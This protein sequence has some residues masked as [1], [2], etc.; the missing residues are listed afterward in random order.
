MLS[1]ALSDARELAVLWEAVLGRLQIEVNA[2]AF[3][4]Y[5]ADT[6]A[7]RVEAGALVVETP[8]PFALEG[9]N[10]LFRAVA[11]RE[12]TAVA[13]CELGVSF[14]PHRIHDIPALLDGPVQV[15]LPSLVGRLNPAFTFERYVV[16][17]GNR[18]AHGCCR[19]ATAGRPAANPIVLFGRPGVGKTHLLHALAHA[20]RSAGWTIACLSAEEFTNDYQEA[21]RERSARAFQARVRTVRLLIVDDLQYLA[22]K[23]GTQDEF[24]RTIEAVANSG[25]TVAVASEADPDTLALPER[26]ISRLRAGARLPLAPLEEWDRSALTRQLV[27]EYG[28]ALPDDVLAR[29]AGVP[30]PCV[31]DLQGLVTAVAMTVRHHGVDLARIDAAILGARASAGAGGRTDRDIIDA[32]ARHFETSFE[33]LVGSRRAVATKARAVA[34]ALLQERGRSLAQIKTVVPRDR[35]SILDAGNRGRDLLEGDPLLRQAV[36]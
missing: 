20:A 21:V 24:V 22:G 29:I 33:E 14:V 9:L 34:V 2:H 1:F 7:L 27:A 13:G 16:T 32:V 10:L 36:G 17:D 12:V 35:S 6:R 26:L 25:G 3:A 23:S 28:C 31:R 19:E 11:E 18:V 5:L 8:K 15:A 30:V 4:T